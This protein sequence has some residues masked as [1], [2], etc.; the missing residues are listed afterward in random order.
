[1]HSSV[2]I[3]IVESK[4]LIYSINDTL[5]FLGRCAIVKIDKWLAVNLPVKYRKIGSYFSDIFH[6]VSL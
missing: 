3:A 6:F 2:D 5:W 1:M 4:D